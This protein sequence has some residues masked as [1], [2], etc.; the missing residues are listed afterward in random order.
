M[1]R[2]EVAPRTARPSRTERRAER[3]YASPAAAYLPGAG[4]SDVVLPDR[5]GRV[6][7]RNYRLYYRRVGKPDRGTVVVLHG[8]PGSTQ[9]YLTPLADLAGAGYQVVF[10]D[11]LGCGLSER[12]VSY[13]DYTIASSADD[14]DRLRRRL[15]LGRVHLFGHSYGGALALEAAVRHPHAWRSLVVASGYAS[16]RTLWKARRLR[17][18]QLSPKNRRALLRQDRTGIATPASLRAAE[19]FRRRF[20]ERT[21]NRAF[22]LLTTSQHLNRRILGAMGYLSPRLFDDG[23]VTGTMAGWDVTEALREVRIPTLITVGQFDHVTPGCAREIHRSIPRSRLVVV[24]G[25]G[26]LP[27]YEDRDRYISLVRGF[28]DRVG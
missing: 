22:E 28:L 26:H 24:R 5:N 4:P 19:E 9:E 20:T 12:P 1:G 11:Q 14:A 27:F 8:G 16:M 13:R 21:E 23:F 10:Y 15:K 17:I 7:I 6:R 3:S 18:S 25:R 2:A